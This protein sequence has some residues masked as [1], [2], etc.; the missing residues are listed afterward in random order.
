M[1]QRQGMQGILYLGL[2][3]PTSSSQWHSPFLKNS[4]QVSCKGAAFPDQHWVCLRRSRSGPPGSA[5]FVFLALNPQQLATH[6]VCRRRLIDASWTNECVKEGMDKR[7][8][9]SGEHRCL[10]WLLV[11]RNCYLSC[12]GKDW[13]W[14][15]GA[16]ED[17]MIGWHHRF[18]GH[19]FEQTPEDSRGRGPW[20]AAAHGVTNSWTWLSAWTTTKLQYIVRNHLSQMKMFREV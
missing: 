11:G 13:R 12:L 3:L 15:Q 4:S 8:Q 5:D 10:Q 18:N 20:Q 19:E 9:G 14:K 2:L 17:G 7:G 16:A 1:T 6:L